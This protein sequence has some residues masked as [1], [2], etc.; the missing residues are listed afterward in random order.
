MIGTT[1]SLEGRRRH[2][3]VTSHVG[4]TRG[5]STQVPTD[6]TSFLLT[7]PFMTVELWNH[8]ARLVAVNVPDRNKHTANVI[9]R[10][11]TLPEYDDPYSAHGYLG[12]TIGRTAN[13]IGNA[14]FSLDGEE[15]L[16]S[17]NDG[18]NHL[19]GGAIGF[20]Q[21]VWAASHEASEEHASV[22]MTLES[23]AGDQGYPGALTM[24]TSFRLRE[25]TLHIETTATTS[26]MTIVG[27]TNHAYWNLAGQGTIE[28]HTLL[29]AA[30]RYVPVDDQLIP[31]GTLTDVEGTV[32]DFRRRR[33]LG[34]VLAGGGLDH[35]MVFDRAE[36]Q[37]VILEDPASGRAMRMSTNQPGVQVYT[38]SYLPE[39]FTGV[40]LEPQHL[41]DTP[42]NPL[43]GSTLLV[44]GAHYRHWTTYEFGSAG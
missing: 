34:P 22:E 27:T 37:P 4:R 23:P 39:P 14:R 24:T 42:N 38:G 1:S 35:C 20:D 32:F 8:G 18:V 10:Y 16:L 3:V 12:A 6:V 5:H 43:Y 36:P 13:R 30:S 7:S 19:H 21:H 2:H 25:N 40:C 29:V 41:P 28:H 33:K 26:S 15:C 17:A 11:A 9:L 31:I 44:P